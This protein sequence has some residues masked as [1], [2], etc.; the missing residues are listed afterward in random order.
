MYSMPPY[1][2]VSVGLE[3]A[4]CPGSQFMQPNDSPG[5][6]NFSDDLCINNTR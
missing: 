3:M 6:K 5:F 4:G 2:P 1:R